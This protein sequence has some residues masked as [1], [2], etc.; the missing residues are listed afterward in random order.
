MTPKELMIAVYTCPR[1]PAYV[2][3]A[4]AT[5]YMSGPEIFDADVRLVVDHRDPSSFLRHYTVCPNLPIKIYPLTEEEYQYIEK[6]QDSLSKRLIAQK[7]D[8]PTT[9][10]SARVGYTYARC[11]SL[12]GDHIGS[13]LIEDDCIVKPGMLHW[14]MKAIE[15]VE[16]NGNIEYIITLNTHSFV[17]AFNPAL[18]AGEYTCRYEYRFGLQGI[19]FKRAIGRE[20]A[21]YMLQHLEGNPADFT[22]AHFLGELERK[23]NAKGIK[24]AAVAYSVFY[25]QVEHIG[26]FSTGLGGGWCWCSPTFALPS[27][28]RSEYLAQKV[29]GGAK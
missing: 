7:Y 15:E 13:L 14:L 2:D 24:Q 12:P 16:S 23:L 18:H 5:L 29:S 22:L 8:G 20:L 11:L 26:E 25:D 3:S 19:Y 4:L 1:K 28:T 6:V 27:I 17:P 10:L 21:S 9:G